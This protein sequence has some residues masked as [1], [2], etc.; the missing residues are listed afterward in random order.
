MSKAVLTALLEHSM[1]PYQQSRGR[2]LQCQAVQVNSSFELMV[3]GSCGF[4]LQ[5]C[6]IIALSFCCR[7]WRFGFVN[8]QVSL[9]SILKSCSYKSKF[10]PLRVDSI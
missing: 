8:G 7:H 1:C 3:A 2:G 10:F 4:T 9:G 5:I 6:L